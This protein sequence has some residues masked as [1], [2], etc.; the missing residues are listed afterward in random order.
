VYGVG[1]RRLMPIFLSVH[2]PLTF[3]HSTEIRSSTLT[4]LRPGFQIRQVSAKFFHPTFRAYSPYHR[5]GQVPASCRAVR[6][7]CT[8]YSMGWL[9]YESHA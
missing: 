5:T 2:N 9:S 6:C 7:F 3:P 4:A 8:K 1:Q